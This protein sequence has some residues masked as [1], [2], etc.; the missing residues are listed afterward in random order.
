MRSSVYTQLATLEL[1]PK[2]QEFFLAVLTSRLAVAVVKAS[3]VSP[4]RLQGFPS[5]FF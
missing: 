2:Q 5:Q 4:T 3:R 1:W